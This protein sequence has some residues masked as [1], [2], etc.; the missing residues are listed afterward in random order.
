VAW[1]DVHGAPRVR[2][3]RALIG[4]IAVLTL[5]SP[6]LSAIPAA[7]FRGLGLGLGPTASF[8]G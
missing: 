1:A 7:N 8:P 6:W 3:K 5:A 2:L 4:V